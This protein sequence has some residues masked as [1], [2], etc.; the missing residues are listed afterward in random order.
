[1][2]RSSIKQDKE[3]KD[4]KEKV[5]KGKN[6]NN[7]SNNNLNKS[8]N[9]LNNES[10]IDNSNLNQNSIDIVQNS[11]HS[12][13]PVK[14][15]SKDTGIVTNQTN[16]SELKKKNSEES[17]LFKNDNEDE[18]AN[19][20]IKVIQINDTIENLTKLVNQTKSSHEKHAEETIKFVN[21]GHELRQMQEKDAESRRRIEQKTSIIDRISKKLENDYIHF[22]NQNNNLEKNLK[23]S[24]SI[25]TELSQEINALRGAKQKNAEQNNKSIVQLKIT[26]EQHLL[27]FKMLKQALI[28]NT[29]NMQNDITANRIN[30]ENIDKN[31]KYGI[32]VNASQFKQLAQENEELRKNFEIIKKPL[33]EQCSQLTEQ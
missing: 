8:K 18:V 10:E 22:K 33:V 28:N 29:L 13:D 4:Q 27:E 23:I 6:K 31:F 12:N 15:I 5:Q 32:D 9:E 30:K 11:T 14:D 25:V 21:I 1:M 24:E 7:K 17:L 2:R 20:K 3:S 19:L 26:L 16:K